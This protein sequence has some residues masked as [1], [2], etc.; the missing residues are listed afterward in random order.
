MGKFYD[1]A[2]GEFILGQDPVY[3]YYTGEKTGYPL[4]FRLYEEDT[5]KINQ[6]KGIDRT[7]RGAG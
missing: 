1:H 4:G 7:L 5:T 2:E 3:T 6:A